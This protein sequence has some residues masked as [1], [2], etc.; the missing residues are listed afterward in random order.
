MGVGG[1]GFPGHIRP[2]EAEQYLPHSVAAVLGL[3]A[4]SRRTRNAHT[5]DTCRCAGR[6]HGGVR[7]VL[8]GDAAR[9]ERIDGRSGPT[10]EKLH[11]WGSSGELPHLHVRTRF[12]VTGTFRVEPFRRA[13]FDTRRA[14]EPGAG[15]TRG[16]GIRCVPATRFTP[17]AFRPQISEVVS[18]GVVRGSTGTKFFRAD[19]VGERV[20]QDHARQRECLLETVHSVLRWRWAADPA[21][22]RPG[23]GAGGQR[24]ARPRRANSPTRR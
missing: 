21:G 23:P 15:T 10:V 9:S 1:G 24:P 19:A 4:V 11:G 22:A 17:Q 2:G 6:L 7:V 5:V 3:S 8:I 18:V 13:G 20:S 14:G 12:R 16:D